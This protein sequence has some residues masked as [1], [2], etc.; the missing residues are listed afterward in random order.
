MNFIKNISIQSKYSKIIN[1]WA[2]CKFH[3]LFKYHRKLQKKNS[4]IVHGAK[5]I[6]QK[7]LSVRQTES[8]IRS[9]KNIKKYSNDKKDANI[10][11]LENSVKE[12]TGINVSITNKKNN[13]GKL[14]FEYMDL[15]QLNR[16]I[17]V[18]KTN[19]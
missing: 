17:T 3:L 18:I 5:K 16:L 10:I 6:V 9:F 1:S 14:S 4:M 11:S 2:D 13:T 12:K 19:F 15:D 7:R 8:L